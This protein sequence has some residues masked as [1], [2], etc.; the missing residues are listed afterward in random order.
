MPP[1]PRHPIVCGITLLDLDHT[2]E[3]GATLEEIAWHKAGI[4]KPGHPLIIHPQE[5][6]VM[7][8]IVHRARELQVCHTT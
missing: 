4:G 2:D 6:G 3:L 5:P 8:I 1:F 7:D